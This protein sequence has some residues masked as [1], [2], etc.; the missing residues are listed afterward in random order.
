MDTHA[1]NA[2]CCIQILE[3]YNAH[4][5]VKGYAVCLQVIQEISL[6]DFI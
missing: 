1:G 2:T 5:Y 6:F 4:W 3:L